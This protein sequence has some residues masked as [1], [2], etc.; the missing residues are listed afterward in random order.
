MTSHCSAKR[1]RR[2]GPHRA[3]RQM[4]LGRG[5]ADVVDDKLV[6]G[7]LQIR[8]HA[9]THRAEPDETD[10]HVSLLRDPHLSLSRATPGTGHRLS[11]HPAAV[12]GATGSARV[13]G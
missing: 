5:A 9:G 10:L 12:R 6:T 13:R 3:G 7:L 1:L 2:I 4:A 8:R 11:R